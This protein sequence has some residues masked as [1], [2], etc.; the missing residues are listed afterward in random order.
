MIRVNSITMKDSD[1]TANVFLE[2][3]TKDEVL[4]ATT[5]DIIGFPKGYTIDFFSKCLTSDG[6]VGIMQSDGT[7]NF[8]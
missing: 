7:W 2:A 3:D 5:D 8:G 6:E 1:M 4:S